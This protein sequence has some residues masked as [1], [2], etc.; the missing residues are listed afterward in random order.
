MGGLLLNALS[1]KQPS[2][3]TFLVGLMPRHICPSIC[4]VDVR[5][6]SP[7]LL[8]PD[9]PPTDLTEPGAEPGCGCDCDCCCVVGALLT[10][11]LLLPLE[12]RELQ[13]E[14]VSP[15][16]P[17]YIRCTRAASRSWSSL[18]SHRL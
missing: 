17:T 16:A 15:A 6:R 18:D 11:L 2:E 5:K 13:V 12:W 3:K 14:A 9:S 8:L 1:C 10:K 7:I 4:L